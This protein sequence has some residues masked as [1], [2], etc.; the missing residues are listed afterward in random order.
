MAF[1]RRSELQNRRAG[2]GIGARVVRGLGFP[3][4][5][6]DDGFDYLA[7][8]EPPAE[9]GPSKGHTQPW[10]TLRMP[11]SASSHLEESRQSNG[12]Q[13]RVSQEKQDR[14]VVGSAGNEGLS[15]RAR[16]MTLRTSVQRSAR[17]TLVGGTRLCSRT[18]PGLLP[19]IFPQARESPRALH[20][21]GQ[22]APASH[23][24]NPFEL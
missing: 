2:Q 17:Q 5:G 12:P 3:G 6:R 18:T 16:S 8:L 10:G 14:R 1:L 20:R 13:A 19:T 23:G 21:A 15:H 9:G 4:Q 11:S 7:T 24:G 22:E